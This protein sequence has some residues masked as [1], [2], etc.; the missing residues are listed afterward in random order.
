MILEVFSDEAENFAR[1]MSVS[2]ETLTKIALYL[3]LLRDASS[4]VNLVSRA[5]LPHLWHRH[6]MDSAQLVDLA[7]SSA[8]T[9]L[10]LGSGA[11]FPSVV[12]ALLLRDQPE[13]SIHLVESKKKKILFLE[14]VIKKTGI[15]AHLYPQRVED[16]A[17]RNPPQKLPSKINVLTARALAPL[18]RL[19]DLIFP[20]FK[21][22]PN[23]IA[24]LPKGHN[25]DR[26]MANLSQRWKIKY[27][28]FSSRTDSRA[29]ILKIRSLCRV[30]T[31]TISSQK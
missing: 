1:E 25:L 20:F 10:D 11:G 3:D 16:M 9:W 17:R 30:P 7:P 8:K 5:D 18:P 15:K 13:F 21:Q 19:L 14:D 4:K 31:H 29:R 28:S 23:M 24:L 27:D 6:V 2:R 12:L 22:N 26:E